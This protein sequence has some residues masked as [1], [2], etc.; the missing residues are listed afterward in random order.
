M[1]A[2]LPQPG[3]APHTRIAAVACRVRPFAVTLAAGVPLGQAVAEA[4]ETARVPAAWLALGPST[5]SRLDYMLPGLDPS[6]ARAAWYDG[7]HAAGAVDL[8]H[9]GLHAGWRDGARFIHCHGGWQGMPG[10]AFGHLIPDACTLSAPTVARGWAIRGCTLDVQPDD[11]TGF[12]LFAPTGPVPVFEGRRAVLCSLRPNQDIG[13]ALL[14]AASAGG[15]AQGVICGLGSLVHPVFEGQAQIDS[16]ATEFLFTEARIWGGST[17]LSADLVAIGGGVHR[18]RLT[19][20]QNG[21]C[22]TAEALIIDDT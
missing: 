12:A 21:I 2:T 10:G 8:T 7:P 20:G 17:R 6:G 1:I 16:L 11:E 15:I 5:F 14:A 22:I 18:G 9:A 13:A 4:L 19:P 3:P